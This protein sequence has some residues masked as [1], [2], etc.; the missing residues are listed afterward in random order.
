MDAWPSHSLLNG[1][2]P[3]PVLQNRVEIL[4]GR[5]EVIVTAKE[6]INLECSTNTRT[7]MLV[8]F[9]HPVG[10]VVYFQTLF[11]NFELEIV[12]SDNFAHLKHLSSEKR[13]L[14]CSAYTSSQVLTIGDWP[15]SLWWTGERMRSLPPREHDQFFCSLGLPAMDDCGIIGIWTR[16]LLT[17]GRM[18]FCC[19]FGARN[20]SF[21]I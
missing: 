1:Q 17:I 14:P 3:F 11:T 13:D 12:L 2:I 16:S 18:L 15:T 19:H 10:H 6:G 8:R 7:F 21:S 4:R 5:V 9:L 20:A